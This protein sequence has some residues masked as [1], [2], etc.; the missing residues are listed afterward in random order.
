MGDLVSDGSLVLLAACA[1]NGA[2]W[3]KSSWAIAWMIST[4]AWGASQ[5][6]SAM[7]GISCVPWRLTTA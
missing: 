2:A 3:V 6:G 5:K 4:L 1:I 7:R